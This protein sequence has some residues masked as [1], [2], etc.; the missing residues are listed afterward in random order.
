MAR[1]PL[2]AITNRQTFPS[3]G[4]W[5]DKADGQPL[6]ISQATSEGLEAQLTVDTETFAASTDV[7]DHQ[8]GVQPCRRKV[9]Y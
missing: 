9:S 2:A 1:H 8:T 6:E 5:V 7:E 3:A 4:V